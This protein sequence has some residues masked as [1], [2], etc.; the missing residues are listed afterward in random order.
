MSWSY[1][2]AA[3]SRAVKE[4][5]EKE[6]QRVTDEKLRIQTEEDDRIRAGIE[7]FGVQTPEDPQAWWTYRAQTFKDPVGWLLLKL[8]AL[9][10][11]RDFGV[12][13]LGAIH[14]FFPRLFDKP[15]NAVSMGRLLLGA[16]G[17]LYGSYQVERVK[18]YKGS[19]R[20]RVVNTNPPVGDLSMKEEI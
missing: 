14:R 13:D 18:R 9:F 4:R 12:K 15:W 10:G 5:K 6:A 17:K 20:W 1:A 7:L 8:V 3:R 16:E 19:W 2:R 11:H